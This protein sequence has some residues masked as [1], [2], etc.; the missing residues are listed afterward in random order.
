MKIKGL[1]LL[2]IL[3]LT[4]SVQSGTTV[5]GKLFVTLE[6][7]EMLSGTKFNAENNASRLGI[8]GSTE[9][10]RDLEF[11][12][13]AEY[14]VDPVDGTADESNGRTFKQRNTFI[15]FKGSLGTLF[16]G[17]HDTA[18]RKS[19][20]KIDLFNDLASDIKN[21]LEGENR[22]S[23]LVGFTTPVFGKNFSATFNVIKEKDGLDEA[24]SFSLKYKSSNI[25]AA[26][27]LDSKVKG[28]DSYRVSF[29]I[30]FNKAQ[31]GLMFQTSKEVNT[32]GK[33]EGYVVSLS[34][35]IAN[36]G[37]IKLQL[38]ESD[39]KLVSGKQ[40]TFGYD[41]ELSKKAKIFIFY[42]DLSNPKIEKEGNI[43]AVGFELKF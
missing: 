36:K 4:F 16:L 39:I 26:L 24:S 7:Q 42:T 18:F 32:G 5:Y 8:K 37:K 40:T 21:I 27:A 28:Y 38:T 1:F 13:Q 10:K 9:L 20:D 11:I 33:E 19:Q 3:L 2:I 29:Q 43:T 31:L 15:G 14:E 34:R 25:Y 41:L 17:T 35:K 12:Y 23:E 22:L 6:S 30:P